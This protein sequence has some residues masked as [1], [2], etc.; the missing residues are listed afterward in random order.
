[1]LVPVRSPT[2]WSLR[3]ILVADAVEVPDEVESGTGWGRICRQPVGDIIDRPGGHASF[4][5]PRGY[6]MILLPSKSPADC[7]KVTLRP[8]TCT[9]SA[10]Y[11][12]RDF[13]CLR[14]PFEPMLPRSREPHRGSKQSGPCIAHCRPGIPPSRQGCLSP[15]PMIMLFSE[16]VTWFDPLLARRVLPQSYVHPGRRIG[17]QG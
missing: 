1:M 6:R 16:A 9:A 13:S 2:V 14:Y 4:D 3:R 7:L 15:G 5:G 17:S 12:A 11:T 8:F 10:E